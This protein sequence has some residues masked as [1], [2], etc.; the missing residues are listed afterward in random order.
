[1]E[2]IG[3][4]IALSFITLIKTISLNK[5]IRLEY[6]FEILINFL[7]DTSL[8][9][10]LLLQI[11]HQLS[12]GDG[13][14]SDQWLV[15]AFENVIVDCACQFWA[16]ERASWEWDREH[17][18]CVQGWICTRGRWLGLDVLDC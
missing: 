5:V 13:E 6:L 4:S 1:M 10:S 3:T 9:S 18:C 17:H 12:N 15:E 11:E 8:N 2:L 7:N 16:V 14:Y